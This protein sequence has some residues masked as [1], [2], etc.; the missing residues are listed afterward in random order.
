[1]CLFAISLAAFLNISKTPEINM[2]CIFTEKKTFSFVFTFPLVVSQ[3]GKN[4]DFLTPVSYL[5][6]LITYNSEL[7]VVYSIFNY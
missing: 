7:K 5:N 4:S 6:S 3:N 1:M 2:M